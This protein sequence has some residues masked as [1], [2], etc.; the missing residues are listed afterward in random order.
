MDPTGKGERKMFGMPYTIYN[1]AKNTAGVEMSFTFRRDGSEWH[2]FE[3]ARIEDGMDR[4]GKVGVFSLAE[5]ESMFDALL[6]AGF[7]SPLF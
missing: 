4:H 5:A 6:A 1:V 3:N 7:E 2:V